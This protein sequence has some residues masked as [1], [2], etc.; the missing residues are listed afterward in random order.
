MSLEGSGLILLTR[1]FMLKFLASAY[2]LTLLSSGAV[3]V[4][5][6]VFFVGVLKLIWYILMVECISK[7]PVE[8]G[9][10]NLMVWINVNVIYI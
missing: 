8:N 10:N 4:F 5:M 2:V 7:A 6:T 3:L 1:I 9:F